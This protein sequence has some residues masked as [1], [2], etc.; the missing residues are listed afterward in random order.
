MT[1]RWAR[2]ASSSRIPINR[3]PLVAALAVSRSMPKSSSTI[4]TMSEAVTTTELKFAN[5]GI[6]RKIEVPIVGAEF[7]LAE[8]DKP[9]AYMIRYEG[10]IITVKPTELTKLSK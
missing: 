1:P 6:Y 7:R 8:S 5:R 2:L 9:A 10:K 3:G 4:S